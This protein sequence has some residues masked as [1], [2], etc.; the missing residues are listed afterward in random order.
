M[1]HASCKNFA[2]LA[3]ARFFLGVAEAAVVPGFSLVTGIFYK[4]EEQ[5]KRHVCLEPVAL[6][7][8]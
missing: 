2:G 5:P 6:K 4:R 1:C 8:I 7:F 3:T